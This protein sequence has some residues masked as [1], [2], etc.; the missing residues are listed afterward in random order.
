MNL[1]RVPEIPATKPDE[2]LRIS[3]ND[4]VLHVGPVAITFQRTLRIP[5]DCST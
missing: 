5:D 3:V 1:K 4:D 2:P